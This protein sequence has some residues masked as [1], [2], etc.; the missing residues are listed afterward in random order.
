MRNPGERTQRSAL[1]KL[2][3]AKLPLGEGIRGPRVE[4]IKQGPEDSM[5]LGQQ[6]RSTKNVPLSMSSYRAL[7]EIKK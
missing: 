7:K 2:P 4:H 6:I 1:S 3:G 5:W